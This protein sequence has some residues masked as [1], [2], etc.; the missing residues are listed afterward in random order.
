MDF[1][2][3]HNILKEYFLE[4]LVDMENKEIVE[5]VFK[6]QTPEIQID[7]TKRPLGDMII[8]LNFNKTLSEE[9]KKK[10]QYI[11]P[12]SN[13]I[14]SLYIDSVSRVNSIRQLKKTMKFIEKFM[15]YEGNYN[16]E[17]K[18]KK[19]HSFQFFKYHSFRDFTQ[20]NF[21]Q[22]YYGR[23]RERGHI[24]LINKYLKNNG[25][26]TGYAGD[27]CSR[28]NTRTLHNLPKDEG[29]DHAFMNC[30][31][32]SGH[33]NSNTIKC[34]YGKMITELLYEYGNQFW[35]KY[36]DNRK[37]LNI[38]VNDGHEG[39]LEA[40]K[41]SDD[42][43][44][45]FLNNLF[46]DNLL[47]DSSI[48]LLSDHGVGMPS[49]YYYFLF[50]QLEI[51]LP[52]LYIIVNDR[53]N[54]S[55]NEQYKYINENQQTFIT[56]YDIYNTFINIIYGDKY[57]SNIAPKSHNGNSLF[58]RINQKSRKPNNYYPMSRLACVA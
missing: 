18:S 17:D 23:R 2:E 7:F 51:R 6:N 14:L 44:Y 24:T 53:K 37:F 39:T 33:F 4:N 30:D 25:Y 47:T 11:I 13:N 8:N 22:I 57:E 3:N 5:K 1:P 49:I 21:P 26:I 50:Y 34:L 41:Y 10:E 55:Y 20:G 48:F 52:M 28:E 56:G 19:F 46:N 9:R 32:N 36:K 12:Y 40:L 35:R 43:I 16:K 15:P 42:I 45:N 58:K 38:V 29:Y 31:P 54:I 27:L